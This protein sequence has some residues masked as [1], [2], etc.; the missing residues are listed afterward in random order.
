MT[1]TTGATIPHAHL[2]G[3]AVAVGRS[4]YDISG[5][6]GDCTD[7]HAVGATNTVDV[8]NTQTNTF[9]SASNIPNARDQAP[10]GAVAG[11]KIYV[12]G[13]SASCGGAAV[14][15]VDMYD[16]SSGNWSTLSTTSNL[17]SSVWAP[18]ACGTAVGSNIYYFTANGVGILN[19]AV[20]PP[21]WTVKAPSSLLNPSSYCKAVSVGSTNPAS[22]SAKI[23][24]T[25]PGD[26]SA[27]ANSQRVIDYLPATN[28]TSL[29]S[30]TT[31]PFAEH[32]VAFLFG[33]LVAAGG[34]FSPGGGLGPSTQVQLIDP[35]HHHATTVTSLPDARDD[36]EGVAVVAST[37][38]IVGGESS[39]TTTPAVMIGTPVVS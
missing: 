16:P 20:S 13:G 35:V 39:S 26:G 34:D 3:A 18:N 28:A 11:G 37:M 6:T 7:G 9:S 1:W 15:P 36:A 17:P 10:V 29:E 24:L 27:D 22:S 5:D 12:I 31:D 38:Y 33:V 8:Y 25:G 32:S 23:V 4:V 21:T 19:T 14:L 30:E 2:E